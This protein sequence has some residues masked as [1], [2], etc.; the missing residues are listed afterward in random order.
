[1]LKHLSINNYALISQLEIEFKSGFSTITGETGAGKSI[2]LG[3]I[4]LILGKRADT[5]SL[6][7][8]NK[9]CIIEG[10]FDIK[11]YTLNQFFEQNEIDFSPETIIR[12][13]ISTSG[14]SRAFINDSQVNLN[15]LKELGEKLID[16]H[17]QHDTLLLNQSN[18]QLN[19]IDNFAG[20]YELVSNFKKQFN[21][22]KLIQKKIEETSEKEKKA[23]LDF[24]YNQFLFNELNEI[25]FDA[26]GFDNAEQELE[27]L[28][29]AESIKYNLSQIAAS[30]SNENGVIDNLKKIKILF[31]SISNFNS[32]IKE[33]KDRIVSAL[34]EIQ[35]IN[36]E[37]EQI[38]ENLNFDPE[39]FE[40]LNQ[41]INQVNNLLQKHRVMKLEEL[42]ALKSELEQKLSENYSLEEELENLKKD[43]QNIEKELFKL[44]EEIEEKRKKSVSGFVNSILA[45]L[46]LLGMPHAAI[47][48]KIE[49]LNQ[50]N[51]N[52]FNSINILF[53]AN[54]GGQLR[55]I[56]KVAS[57]GEMSRFMLAVKAELGKKIA[58]PCIIFDE[59]DTGVS[60]EMATNMAKIMNEMA[61]KMQVI[62]I[63]HLPQI[64]SK[65]QNQYRVYKEISETETFSNIVLLNKNERVEEIAK[66]LS[67]ETL[68]KEAIQNAKS[69]MN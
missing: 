4:E 68:S 16:I 52:G 40:I 6:R 27:T 30:L 53:S 14:S 67:G 17:S 28:N 69:L 8:K 45:Q 59:I 43:F 37:A 47:E 38:E 19:T 29:N 56:Q 65:S 66:M 41:K 60:G 48:V 20:C 51:E 5:N 57:G 18:F 63:T 31:E 10:V 12:R 7:D 39:Q 54:K 55:E 62:S 61:Q 44:A 50:F 33:L 25:Q 46:F 3:A 49:R 34:I 35:D 64:A 13:E 24:D 23:K 15:V 11:N 36:K 1:M 58:L 9:K 2:L 32:N 42:F 22:Y 26:E 21:A